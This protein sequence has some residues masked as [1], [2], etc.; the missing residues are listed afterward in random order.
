MAKTKD[1]YLVRSTKDPQL[2]DQINFYFQRI[3]D[4]LD[5]L[6]GIRGELW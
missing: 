4:R 5:K 2:A 1:S 6:E 3:S